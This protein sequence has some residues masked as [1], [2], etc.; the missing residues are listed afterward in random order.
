MKVNVLAA[1]WSIDKDGAWLHL[2]TRFR[3]EAVQAADEIAL[4]QKSYVAEIKPYRQHR[5]LDA[6]A[7]FWV[8]CGKL[9]E[10]TGIPRGDIYRGLVTDIGGNSEMICVKELAAEKLI[11]GWEHNGLG[12]V[13]KRFKSK[14]DGCVNVEL[15]YGSSTYD[16]KQM[17]RLIDA[18]VFEC[19]EQDIETLPPDELE[20][21]KEE[22]V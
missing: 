3:D 20:R 13:T 6:N 14:I 2:N 1:S 8:L 4:S 7:Y 12:W 19:K 10:K 9:A 16:T 15:F 17:S 21:L 5:S 22:W 11:S 18:I